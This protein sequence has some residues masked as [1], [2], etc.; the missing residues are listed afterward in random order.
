[1]IDTGGQSASNSQGARALKV[2]KTLRAIR[3]LRLI[4]I[5][6]EMLEHRSSKD[7]DPVVRRRMKRVNLLMWFAHAHSAAQQRMASFFG[8]AEKVEVARCLLSSQICVYKALT[9][10]AED[11]KQLHARHTW[12]LEEQYLCGQ[13]L[14]AIEGLEKIIVKANAE[15]VLSSREAHDILHTFHDHTHRWEERIHQLRLGAAKKPWMLG[16]G[17]GKQIEAKVDQP[18]DAADAKL[19][20]QTNGVDGLETKTLQS[21]KLSVGFAAKPTETE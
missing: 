13:T 10:C 4:R 21:A 8:S 11:E 5:V 9:C 16:N 14:V 20:S 12:L 17:N 2:L 19:A 15:G 6:Q 18:L 1:M 3:L 7:E